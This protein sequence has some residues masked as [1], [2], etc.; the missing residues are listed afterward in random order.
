MKRPYSYVL[1]SGKTT[2]LD[3]IAGRLCG[4]SNLIGDV[5][6]NGCKL[7]KE[8]FHNCFAYVLQVMI[9][10]YIYESISV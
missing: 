9:V 7:K 4:S 2:L 8:D 1:G 5:Y 3:A 6:V 10:Q